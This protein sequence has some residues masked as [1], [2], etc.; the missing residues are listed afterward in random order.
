MIEH[1]CPLSLRSLGARMSATIGQDKVLFI[2]FVLLETPP[3]EA[4]HGF[5]FVNWILL[6]GYVGHGCPW[7][8]RSWCAHVDRKRAG[9]GLSLLILLEKPPDE[10]RHG[11]RFIHLDPS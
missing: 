8:P 6:A 11:V 5:R 3:D 1:G 2:V 4:R 10:A 9:S 7:S